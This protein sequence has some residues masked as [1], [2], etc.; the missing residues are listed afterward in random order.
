MS[1]SRVRNDYSADETQVI[2]E[3][4]PDNSMADKTINVSVDDGMI[5]SVSDFC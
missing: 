2:E 4:D 1:F 5:L 3:D